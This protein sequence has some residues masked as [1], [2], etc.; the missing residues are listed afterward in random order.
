MQTNFFVKKLLILAGLIAL[1]FGSYALARG[2]P[3]VWSA[4][5]ASLPPLVRVHLPAQTVEGITA[6]V[7]SYY[8]DA[9]RIVFRIRIEGKNTPYGID[10]ISLTDSQNMELNTGYGMSADTADP[11]LVVV[12][13]IP[14]Y[15]LAEKRLDG[16]LSITVTSTD[17]SKPAARFHF[18]L[19]L[20]VHPAQT[21]IVNKDGSSFSTPGGSDNS[22][23]HPILLERVVISPS[24]TW[25]Y[26][27]YNKPSEADW[28]TGHDASLNLE[29]RTSG[30]N[31]YNLLYD[32]SMG[33][34][35]KGGEPGWTH[36]GN[37]QRC[38]K[39]GFQI[40]SQVNLPTKLTLTIPALEQSMPEVIPQEQ[41]EAVYP[42]L[43]AQGI[44]LEWH[45]MDHGAYPEWK[46]L[47]SGMNEQE[48]FQ[49]FIE[50][51]GYTYPGPWIFSIYLEPREASQRRRSLSRA[52]QRWSK[53]SGDESTRSRSAPTKKPSRSPP[54]R[55]SSS[56]ILRA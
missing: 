8:A 54:R 36:V 13:M 10:N 49:K 28:M 47:P 6:S 51:L 38:V 42:K 29:N 26:L 44:D 1:T 19:D 9:L 3:E 2:L 32:S 45:T 18:N 41:L 37:Y 48:A 7:E 4:S 5:A 20:P 50:A 24:F 27:C 23:T 39:I 35:T 11:S 30:I 52:N 43:L 21:Y 12:D 16:Q 25:F 46:K 56:T 53:P 40:G 34:G 17:A 33:D 31:T 15:A 14:A 55:E 22:Y